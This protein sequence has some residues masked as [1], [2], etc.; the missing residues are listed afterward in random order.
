PPDQLAGD[1][2]SVTRAAAIAGEQ[3][4]VPGAKRSGDPVDDR[5]DRLDQMLIAERRLDHIARS[6]Q[7]FDDRPRSLA[8]SLSH[9]RSLIHRIVA[10]KSAPENPLA[11]LT[12]ER[13]PQHQSS[14]H[15]V[16]L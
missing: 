16:A 2:L 8:H 15:A 6:P 11:G 13:T 3:Y 12:T 7:V 5:R 10:P 4:L 14:R 1:V 9:F